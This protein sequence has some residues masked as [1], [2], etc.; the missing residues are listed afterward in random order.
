MQRLGR[1]LDAFHG[2][3]QKPWDQEGKAVCPDEKQRTQQVVAAVFQ[4][5]G[6]EQGKFANDPP[7]AAASSCKTA[8]ESLLSQR[9]CC[10][11]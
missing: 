8:A 1:E 4:Q 5:I 2:K 3:L 11:T 10:A 6:F 9:C 7:L